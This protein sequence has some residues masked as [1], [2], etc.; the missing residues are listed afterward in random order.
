MSQD[1][2]LGPTLQLDRLL[3]ILDR[4]GVDFVVVGGI[5][6]NAHGSAYATF[7]LDVAYARDKAN[8]GRLAA[9]L[10]EMQATLRGA[11]ADLPFQ[12]DAKALANG[13]NF[14]FDTDF[15][16]FDALGEID[17]IRNYESLR[18]GSSVEILNDV[19]VR[20]ASI[21]HLI[22]MKRAAN[23]PKDRMAVEEYIV[24]A[25]EQKKLAR[26]EKS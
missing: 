11:P 15:G 21:N 7:D 20:I 26:E 23:R 9:A 14:T 1:D 12:R 22:S 16:S 3:D 5:A 17:G 8:L 2:S 4:H 19:A 13:A 6:G 10:D 25:E 24:I 18:A